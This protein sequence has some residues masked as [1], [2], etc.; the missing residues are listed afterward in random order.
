MHHHE[1]LASR[2]SSEAALMK[3]SSRLLPPPPRPPLR[4][5]R[6]PCRLPAAVLPQVRRRSAA[7]LQELHALILRRHRP[8]TAKPRTPAVQEPQ[9]P[10]PPPSGPGS[11]SELGR[12]FCPL[13]EP[14]THLRFLF[15]A[16]ILT[17]EFTQPPSS[18]AAASTLLLSL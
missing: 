2:G 5:L 15:S 8:G 12:R 13:P 3:S 7:F 16:P 17:E 11:S 1:E 4:C 6:G 14:E 9:S 10:E 18:A